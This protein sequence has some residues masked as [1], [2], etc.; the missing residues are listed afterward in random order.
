MHFTELRDIDGTILARGL[1]PAIAVV[2]ANGAARAAV[3]SA[4][5]STRSGKIVRASD[6]EHQLQRATA[7]AEDQHATSVDQKQA[8]MADAEHVLKAAAGVAQNAT[9]D[10]TVATDDLARFDDLATRLASAEEAYEAAVRSDAEAARCLAA[11]L[12][13]LDRALG[14]RQSA[15]TSLEQARASGDSSAEPEAVAQEAMN[16]Q[17]AFAAAEKEKH[18]AVGQADEISQAARAASRDA[19]EALDSAHSALR[20]GMALISS[21]APDWG[22]GLPLRGLVTNYRDQLAMAVSTKQTAEVQAKNSE[23]SAE[24]MLEQERMD[25]EALVAAGRPSLDPQGTIIEGWASNYFAKDDV[26]FADDAFDSFSPDG[27][28]ALI[29]SLADRAGQVIYLTDNTDVL[30]W[31]IGLPHEIGGTTTV[32]AARVSIPILL[33]VSG[34][35]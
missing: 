22:P 21:G 1:H 6:V 15:S 18:D 33:E 7:I 25:L 28:A 27:T 30:G 2:A 26:V 24:A 13:E 16:L 20:S 5:F 17:A 34:T 29:T 12:S 32:P 10:S 8:R 11:A 9:L 4:A 31:A 19:M 35:S 3:L 23:R 14:Q